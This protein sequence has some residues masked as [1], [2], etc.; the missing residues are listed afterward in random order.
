M[1]SNESHEVLPS[2]Y[3]FSYFRFGF[4]GRMWDL[5][6][7][8]PDHCLSFYFL[9][10]NVYLYIIMDYKNK[11]LQLRMVTVKMALFKA[12]LTF[13]RE[14]LFKTNS[15]VEFSVPRFLKA[16][17]W[18]GS[19]TIPGMYHFCIGQNWIFFW[20]FVLYT[21]FLIFL[22]ILIKSL[23]NTACKNDSM[24]LTTCILK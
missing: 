7:S 3:V 5:I 23:P 2:I 21:F 9:K 19:K 1:N 4:E 22:V 12:S 16:L 11:V 18:W 10:Q 14:T 20:S 8:V 6:V 15:L 17:R 24:K 13:Q